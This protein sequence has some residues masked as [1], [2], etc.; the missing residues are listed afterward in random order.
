M[1]Q[2]RRIENIVSVVIEQDD[3]T[4]FGEL[5]EDGYPIRKDYLNRGKEQ[6]SQLGTAFSGP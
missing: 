1:K 5:V 4:D 6:E 2:K 3:S